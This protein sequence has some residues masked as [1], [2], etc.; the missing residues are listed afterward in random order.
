M[1]TT[2]NQAADYPLYN[3]LGSELDLSAVVL[4]LLPA[5][6]PYYLSEWNGSAVLAM[7]VSA[8]M[9]IAT[10][11]VIIKSFRQVII[12]GRVQALMFAL[13]LLVLV[14]LIFSDIYSA[15]AAFL[16][17]LAQAG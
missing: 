15:I 5:Q 14:T 10:V 16:S 3:F 4:K 13:F 17:A 7:V 9:L 2:I 12:R 8:V 1:L 11:A 6:N